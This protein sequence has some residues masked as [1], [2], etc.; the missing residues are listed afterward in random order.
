MLLLKFLVMKTSW[1]LAILSFKIS[2]WISDVNLTIDG[3]EFG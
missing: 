2:L 1:Q 3:L